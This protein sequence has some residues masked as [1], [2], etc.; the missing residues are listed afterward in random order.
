MKLQDQDLY[1]VKQILIIMNA[2][3]VIIL[4]SGNLE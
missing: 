2:K 4:G 3:D 1:M